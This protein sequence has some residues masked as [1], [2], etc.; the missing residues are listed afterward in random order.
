MRLLILTQVVDQNDADL[1]FFHRW[2]EKI[3]EKVDE[4]LV[5]CLRKGD[6][7]LPSNVTVLSL[8]KERGGS[9]LSYLRRLFRYVFFEKYDH[10]FV[11][12]NPEYIVLYG[13]WWRLK[14]KKV[15]LWYT[16]K[17]VNF[18]LR[19][20]EKL[21]TKIFTASKESFRLP[22]NKVEVVGHGVDVDWFAYN[23]QIHSTTSWHL[24]WVGRISPVK[25]LETVI[26]AVGELRKNHSVTLDIIGEPITDVDRE[27]QRAIEALMNELGITGTIHFRGSFTHEKMGE[28]YGKHTALIHTS[29]TGSVDKVVLEAMAG[30]LPVFTSSE[31]YADFG[32]LVIHF[33]AND[34]QNLAQ[35]IEKNLNF[36]ILADTAKRRNFVR[37]YHNVD[38]LADRIISYF[39]HS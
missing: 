27:Y 15:L 11:H 4:L 23:P 19:I 29:R 2:I 28:E 3:A 38:T 21:A 39:K 25:D 7:R 13:W 16:H 9:R 12:M 24:L 1:G 14:K 33:G 6:Y 34:S 26:R 5:I 22:S 30:G 18:K 35:S 20:A 31:A 10:V 32:D 8:G 17:A 36:A 37:E